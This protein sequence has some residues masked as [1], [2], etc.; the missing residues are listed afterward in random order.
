L[1]WIVHPFG[2]ARGMPQR[3]EGTI[4]FRSLSAYAR[5]RRGTKLSI[6]KKKRA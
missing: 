5:W 4:L 1:K 3:C 6:L 2:L